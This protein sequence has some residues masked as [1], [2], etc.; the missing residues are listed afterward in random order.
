MTTPLTLTLASQ[1]PA[2]LATLRAAG[3][4]PHVLVSHVDEAALIT[5]LTGDA[6]TLVL[7]LARAK[8]TA[9]AEEIRAAG[10]NS[11]HWSDF[12]IGCDSMFEFGGQVVGKPH[13]AEIAR[14]RLT[15][16]QGN[17]GLLYTG[18]FLIHLPSG[19]CLGEVSHA[20]VHVGEMTPAEID[21]YIACGE[22]LHVAGSFT[23]DGFGGPFIEHVEGDYHG[24]VGISLPLVRHM[25]ADLG[26]SITELW[27][28]RN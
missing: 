20:R 18:H 25:L 14:E 13:T 5:S 6:R 4:I 12:V 16:M 26:F 24:V 23:V 11:P 9:V 28:A 10:P 21:A 8:A 15:H 7:A 27:N 3:I 19:R 1:S 2:R 17:S 22:P